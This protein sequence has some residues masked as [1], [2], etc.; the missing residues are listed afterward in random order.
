MRFFFKKIKFLGFHAVIATREDISIDVS[1]IIT[2]NGNKLGYEAII[3]H[4]PVT[5]LKTILAHYFEI[6]QISSSGKI[7]NFFFWGWGGIKIIT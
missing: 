7:Y 6:F 4:I 5:I 3:H 2:D 1:I